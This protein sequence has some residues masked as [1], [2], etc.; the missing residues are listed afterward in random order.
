MFPSTPEHKR[1]C[2]LLGGRELIGEEDYTEIYSVLTWGSS[3]L[4]RNSDV[5]CEI[6]TEVLKAVNWG[7]KK[8]LYL[9][10]EIITIFINV[11]KS[12]GEF[13]E[14]NRETVLIS[15]KLEA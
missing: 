6:F 3:I 12:A 2:S 7:K 10:I 14:V 8:G 5:D 13:S 9:E 11:V 15:L 1:I 4:Q